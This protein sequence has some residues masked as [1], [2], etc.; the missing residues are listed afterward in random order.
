LRVVLLS[1]SLRTES[2]HEMLVRIAGESAR[3]AV[4]FADLRDF[5]LPIRE[6]EC[7]ARHPARRP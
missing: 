5:A 7:R 3:A 2:F 1:G 4:A 6:T